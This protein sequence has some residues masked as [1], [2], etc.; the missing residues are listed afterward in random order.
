[1]W[2]GKT[3]RI[4][5]HNALHCLT[6]LAVLHIKAYG[7]DV[8]S[9]DEL[10]RQ[11]RSKPLNPA[12]LEKVDRFRGRPVAIG[13]IQQLFSQANEQVEKQHLARALVRIGAADAAAYEYLST[14]ARQAIERN[15]PTPFPVDTTGHLVKGRRSP[16]FVEWCK[17]KGMTED[18]CLVTVTRSDLRDVLLL[19]STNDRRNVPLLLR[20]LESTNAQVV[21]LSAQGL[22]WLGANDFVPRVAAAC[23][24]FSKDE[25]TLIGIMLFEFNDD[26]A[27]AAGRRYVSDERAI[28]VFKEQA[29]RRVEHR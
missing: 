5:H 4:M 26:T 13:E 23:S 21:A 3:S 8:M 12:V 9:T 11:L 24:R 18:V 6:I 17:E 28:R 27:D 7:Q 29:K 14:I 2:P 10:L 15:P 16:Q 22:A 1:M 19:S 25:A 20:G